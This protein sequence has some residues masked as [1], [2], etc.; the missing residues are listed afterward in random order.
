MR[1]GLYYPARA[2]YRRL[3]PS[4]AQ[5]HRD[6]VEFYRAIIAP[7]DLCFDIGAHLGVK[8]E[9]L[10]AAGARVVA[11]E[12]EPTCI[13]ILTAKFTT[14]PRVDLVKRG[15]AA[16]PGK[17]ILHRRPDTL[18]MTSL[19]DDWG[20]GAVEH[21]E[22]E[23]TTLDGLIQA[24]GVPRYI[25]VDVEG[26]ETEVF[27]GLGQRVPLI[28]FEFHL[29]ELERAKD[30]LALLARLG[31]LKLNVTPVDSSNFLFPGWRSVDQFLGEVESGWRHG[32]RGDIY[33]SLGAAPAAGTA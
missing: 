21:V 28:S 23:L 30:C 3:N 22:I 6:E 24:F 2:A 10:L 12:P 25:K 14:H 32:P 33:V 9:A 1:S 31:D 17:A 15:V 4:I 27:K 8:V 20:Y 5:H 7:G 11:V 16:R 29:Q 26:F 18:S 13:A 19:R